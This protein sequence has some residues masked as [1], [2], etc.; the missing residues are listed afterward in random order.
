MSIFEIEGKA[1]KEVVC[2]VAVV[3][4]SFNASGNNSYDI[5]KKVMEECDSFLE[6]IE[7]I[8]IKVENIHLDDE[9]VSSSYYRDDDITENIYLNDF[10]KTRTIKF[11]VE[12]NDDS[13]TETMNN[14]A[15]T[16]A[17]YNGV[18]AYNINVNVI[19]LQ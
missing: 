14:A 7:K 12:W 18:A 19:Q 9:S 17:T 4:V 3:T 10:D 15:D 8:G 2:D 11:Y 16:A 13:Q 5:S 1:T 6:K